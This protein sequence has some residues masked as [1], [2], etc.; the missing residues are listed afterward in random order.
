MMRA[1]AENRYVTIHGPFPLA[2]LKVLSRLSGRK[3]W[4]SSKYVRVEGSGWNIKTLKE[5]GFPLEWEDTFNDIKE[6]E[7]LKSMLSTS[8]PIKHNYHPK[9]ELKNHQKDALNISCHRRAFAWYLEM[10]LG[11]TALAIANFSILFLEN[12]IQAV[13]ILAPK[14]VHKQWISEE[15][16]KHIDPSIPL[17]MT[18]WTNGKYYQ[19]EELQVHGVLNIFALNIDAVNTEAGNFAI[20]QFINYFKDKLMMIIDEAHQIG[21]FGSLRTKETIKLGKKVSYRRV[22]TGTPI[23]TSL[24]NIW[25]QFMFLDSRIIGIDYITAFRT[26]FCVEGYSGYEI[27]DAQNVEEFYSLVAPHSY[28]K[29]KKECLDLPEKIY[30]IRYYQLG[31]ATRKHYENIKEA[32]MT[33]LASGTIVAPSNGLVALVRLQQIMSGFLPDDEEND[34]ASKRVYEIFSYER[35]EIALDIVNQ[36]EGPVCIWARFIPDIKSLRH[37]FQKAGFDSQVATFDRVDEF[38]RGKKRFLIANQSRGIGG[39]LQETG[40]SNIIYYNNSFNYIH[41]VQS[42]DR[43]HRMGMTASTLTIFDIMA[44]K[45]IDKSITENLKG[46][47][48]LSSLALDDIRQLI[49]D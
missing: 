45:T 31:N 46:K 26:R 24:T 22:L 48:S 20:N 21:N 8:E 32:F 38:K 5:S 15:I 2:F 33:E 44:D 42:E 23:A 27:A 35:A 12:K 10:G 16:P 39:N 36:V 29:T 13:L 1:I 28:R 40:C 11:K 14:G 19:K 17:N 6:I 43:F 25:C 7:E 41:R 3:V 34:Q 49:E 47:K 37:V 30:A 4:S 9:Y 18:L